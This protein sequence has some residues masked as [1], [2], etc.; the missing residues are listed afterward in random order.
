M[1]A[2]T[3]VNVTGSAWALLYTAAAAVTITLQATGQGNLLVHIGS[4]PGAGDA[5]RD[6]RLV[7]PAYTRGAERSRVQVTLANTNTVYGRMDRDVS[8][9]VTVAG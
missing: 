1:A 9:K 6:G 5:S 2:T 8:G 7:V 3:N 4:D